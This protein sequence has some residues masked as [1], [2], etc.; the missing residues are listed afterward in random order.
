[1]CLFREIRHKSSTSL[2]RRAFIPTEKCSYPSTLL[3]KMSV[4]DMFSGSVE[5]ETTMMRVH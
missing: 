2:H 5:V 1:M 3:S 4:T